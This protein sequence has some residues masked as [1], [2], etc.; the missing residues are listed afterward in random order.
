[1]QLLCRLGNSDEELSPASRWREY[2]IPALAGN[3]VSL[4]EYMWDKADLD[5]D[6]LLSCLCSFGEEHTWTASFLQD[7]GAAEFTAS[8]NGNTASS[9]RSPPMSH[10]TLWAHG[11]LCWTPEYGP[12]LHSAA[13]ALLGRYE[14]VRH[15]LWRGQAS[16][17]LP[18]IDSV[19]LSLCAYLSRRYGHDWPLRWR[20]PDSP[21]EVLALQESALS[22]QWGYLE[23]LIDNCPHFRSERGFL[24][25][26]TAM[27]WIRNELAHYR[28]I[29][30]KDFASV[31]RKI[32]QRPWGIQ[33]PFLH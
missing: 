27:R 12:E 16:L 19:R 32:R 10:R 29:T 17:L 2:V 31:L 1:M 28:P 6:S 9:L 3:D 13:L 8:V 22:C 5:A 23:R 7:C 15:R 21:D 30:L 4:A 18:F 11:A 14:E 26:V 24:S 20:Q 25:L 33:S